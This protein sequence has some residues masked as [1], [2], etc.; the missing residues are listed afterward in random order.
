MLRK[1]PMKRS[2]VPLKKSK[3]LTSKSQLKKSR[4]KSTPNRDPKYLLDRQQE[5]DKM[6][7]LF[8]EHWELKMQVDGNR[9]CESCNCQLPRENRSLYHH[10]CWPKSSHPEHKYNIDGLMLVCWQCHANIENA[11]MTEETREKI[12]EIKRRVVDIE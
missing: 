3:P 2:T 5:I 6:W 8:D 10:H 9:Y 7:K 12:E 11:H 1:T 4:M